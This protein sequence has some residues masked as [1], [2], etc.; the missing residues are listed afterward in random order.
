MKGRFTALFDLL[1]RSSNEPYTDRD[2]QSTDLRR[3]TTHR[4]RV[5]SLA[6]SISLIG[7]GERSLETRAFTLSPARTGYM[8]VLLG[9]VKKEGF[10]GATNAF[11]A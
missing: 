2:R 5:S 7:G 9:N 10:A 4:G 3:A 11:G 8:F 6:H 1:L